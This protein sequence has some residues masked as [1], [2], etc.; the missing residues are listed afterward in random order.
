MADLGNN[1]LWTTLQSGQ[2]VQTQ[3]LGPEYSYADN[4]QGPSSLGV[5][6]D[7]TFS[8]LGRNS[9]A[10]ATYVQNLITGDPPLGNQ[11]FI[12]TGGTCTAPDGSIQ[13]RMNYINN[14]SSGAASLPAAM[15]EIGSDFNGLIP[16][17][18][19]DIEGLN[20]LHIFS[21][22]LADSSPQC[23]CYSCPTTSG[24]T[25][26]GFMTPELSPDLASSQCQQVDDSYCTKSGTESFT[27]MSSSTSIPTIFAFLGFMYF[28]FSG[29]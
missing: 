9:S 8:Q 3:I 28:V 13:S 12:N 10:I 22:M 19:D 2:N 15:S 27:N 6:T 25:Q 1:S 7:G 5:G 11:F 21:A 17:V 14:M 24:G 18:V 4:I 16:G 29:K 20:P 23:S 26:Y